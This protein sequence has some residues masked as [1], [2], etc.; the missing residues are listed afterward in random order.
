LNIQNSS[1]IP[2]Y[3][4]KLNKVDYHIIKHAGEARDED[5]LGEES[6]LGG[7]ECLSIYKVSQL[8]A[9]EDLLSGITDKDKDAER[10]LGCC[11]QEL[12]CH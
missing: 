6:V 4:C 3:F 9:G 2:F 12:G 8:A 10:H 1:L 7:L 11:W 5:Q